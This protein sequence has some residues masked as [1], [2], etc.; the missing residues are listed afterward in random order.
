MFKG[1][2][3]ERTQQERQREQKM[4]MKDMKARIER[5]KSVSIRVC[6]YPPLLPFFPSW[7]VGADCLAALAC[8]GIVRARLICR[9]RHNTCDS[10][11]AS[12]TGLEGEFGRSMLTSRT[13]ADTTISLTDLQAQ[14]AVAHQPCPSSVVLQASIL[15]S[16][17]IYLTLWRAWH[18]RNP[19]L[20]SLPAWPSS[21]FFTLSCFVKRVAAC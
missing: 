5:F 21:R 2:K 4:L 10:D 14:N 11:I 16:T 12:S 13:Y 3:W 9:R 19:L 8:H 15:I 7:P 18:S 20:C 1:H 17:I 6:T